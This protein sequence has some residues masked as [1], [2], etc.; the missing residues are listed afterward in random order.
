MKFLYKI[1][2]VIIILAIGFILFC[3][4]SHLNGRKN[5]IE[6]EYF[7][8]YFP[9][10][11]KG[12]ALDTANP[13]F[14][15]VKLER[16][17]ITSTT[18]TVIRLPINCRL[19]YYMKIPRKSALKI[20]VKHYGHKN[21]RALEELKIDI[22]ELNR[23]TQ[24]LHSIKLKKGLIKNQWRSKELS[25]E[26]YGDKIVRLSF[27][28]I[29]YSGLSKLSA[30]FIVRPLLILNKKHL[31]SQK[32]MNTAMKLDISREGLKRTNVVIIVL[33]AARP[34][35]FSC[36]GYHRNTTPFI[37]QLAKNS[38]IFENAFSVAPYTIASTTSLFTSLYP[39][40]HRVLNWEQKIPPRMTTLAEVL[41]RHGYHTYASGFIT[42]W[43]A[44]GFKENF[45]LFIH[46]EEDFKGGLYN[47]L[48]GKFGSEEQ[49]EPVFIYIH[50]RPPHAD[51]DPPERFDR[52]SKPDKRVE[53]SDLTKG[54]TLLKLDKSGERLSTEQLQ[55]LLDRYDGNLLWGDW[56][57][58]LIIEGL[59]KYELFDNSLIIITSDHGEA[60]L[61]HD[62]IMHN[63]TVYNEMIKIPLIM[64]LPSYTK[65]HR[66]VITT[67]VENIDVMPTVLDFLHINHSGLNL[68]GQSMLPCMYS[69]NYVGKPYLLARPVYDWIYSF[70]DSH[71]KYIQIANRGELYNLQNDP[72]EKVDLSSE[73]PILY[74]Y[75]RSLAAFFRDQLITAHSEKPTE[76]TLDDNTRAKL[77][78]LGYLQ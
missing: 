50:L 37:D 71:Y 57:V 23:P 60:F 22:Q 40:T 38:V 4:I 8:S 5:Y 34:D 18:A 61:E 49:E 59:R 21:L 27:N 9:Y 41:A 31:Q 77:R 43:A 68:Q 24:L 64:K 56:L 11:Q 29:R 45:D 63:S 76:V 30:G 52:W 28:S 2:N 13:S 12:S 51:Y 66:N 14:E 55:Y 17:N 7:I 46:T 42:A 53:Y 25:L 70:T 75:Y 36:Y 15:K 65:P 54:A 26:Q 58:H 16:L 47:F 69:E 3:F 10:A 44:K 74:G 20:Q 72:H 67:Y 33:D 6:S 1:K 19:D 62:K 39:D 78:S 32:E 35:H 73:Q 48:Q